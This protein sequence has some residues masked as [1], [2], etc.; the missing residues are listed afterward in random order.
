MNP[1]GTI[2]LIGGGANTITGIHGTDIMAIT[3]ILISGLIMS[4]T[5]VGAI[6]TIIMVVIQ[7]SFPMA[8]TDQNL[9]RR[10][11]PA[12]DLADGLLSRMIQAE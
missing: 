1:I 6:I 12:E 7:V 11:M 9:G 3:A 10:T 5:V 2:L 4:I 8:T